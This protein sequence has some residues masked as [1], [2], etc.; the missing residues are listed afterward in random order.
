[1]LLPLA[2]ALRIALEQSRMQRAWAG[3]PK[4]YFSLQVGRLALGSGGGQHDV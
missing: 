4:I 3:K 1:M 2:D